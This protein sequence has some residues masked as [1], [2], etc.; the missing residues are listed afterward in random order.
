MKSVV[1]EGA[2]SGELALLRGTSSMRVSSDESP[3][4]IN[5]MS[6]ERDQ[7]G[8]PKSGSVVWWPGMANHMNIVNLVL[9]NESLSPESKGLKLGRERCSKFRGGERVDGRVGCNVVLEGGKNPTVPPR[10]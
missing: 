8:T 6:K 5:E 7:G 4:S 2:R 9:A 3:R 1:C 10:K